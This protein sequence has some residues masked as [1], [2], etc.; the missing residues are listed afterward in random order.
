ML[1]N[2]NMWFKQAA[3]SVWSKAKNIVVDQ[4]SPGKKL[5]DEI[6]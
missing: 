4:R 5:L 3:T 6:F 2:K 1:Y